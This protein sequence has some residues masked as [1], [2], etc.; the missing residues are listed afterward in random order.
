MAPNLDT[1]LSRCEADL[2]QIL[3]NAKMGFLCPICLMFFARTSVSIEHIVPDA[4]GGRLTTLTCRGCNNTAGAQLDYHLVERVRVEGR[5]KLLEADVAF[6]GTKFRGKVHLP[7]ST[8]DSFRLYGSPKQSNPRE[9]NR[10]FSLLDEGIWHGQE[11]KLRLERKYEPVPSAVALLR[12]AYLLMFR[13]F[14]YRYVFDS[15]AVVVRESISQPTMETDGLKGISWRVD[16]SPPSE[17]G[18]SI[19]TQPREFRSFMVFLTLD[20]SHEHVSAI[21]L[22]PPKTGSE[23]FHTLAQGGK[24]KRYALSS[25][26]AGDYEEIMPLNKVWR[27]VIGKDECEPS[28]HQNS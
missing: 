16:C 5:S 2:L 19:V 10:F 15:S 27:D 4:L 13:L 26:I 8:S 17:I 22:P 23:F 24:R 7:E 1:L 3:P 28:I 14:G 11:L 6:R 25:W 21:A 12:S 18:V 20:K 9:I